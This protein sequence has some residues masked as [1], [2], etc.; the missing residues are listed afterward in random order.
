ME[1]IKQQLVITHENTKKSFT[2]I[3]S[4][5]T[6]GSKILEGVTWTEEQKCTSKGIKRSLDEGVRMAT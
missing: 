2:H 6:M 4:R 1:E 5:S 3:K